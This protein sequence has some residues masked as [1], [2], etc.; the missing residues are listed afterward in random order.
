MAQCADT[1][2]TTNLC[3]KGYVHSAAYGQKKRG[4]G[5][6]L[7]GHTAPR[8]ADVRFE[9]IKKGRLRFS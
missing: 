6:G 4:Q 5:G 7:R 8:R 3:I 2:T 1:P 9:E